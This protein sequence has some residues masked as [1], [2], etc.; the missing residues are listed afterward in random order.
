MEDGKSID[1]V[2]Y[3]SCPVSVNVN[4]L[5]EVHNRLSF[6]SEEEVRVWKRTDS[7]NNE[8]VE[9]CN[10]FVLIL[11]DNAF[12]IS[13]DRLPSGCKRELSRAIKLNKNIYIAYKRASD[14]TINFYNLNI[15]KFYNSDNVS[16]EIAECT[17]FN[18]NKRVT[19]IILT[20]EKIIKYDRRMILLLLR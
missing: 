8:W 11:P 17:L 3:L 19:P 12:I 20:E 15:N 9:E 5:Y 13:F 7:Y 18:S 2:T 4:Y 6:Y 14:K 16:G 1:G 10:N